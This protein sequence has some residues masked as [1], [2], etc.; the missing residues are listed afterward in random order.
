MLEDEGKL[1][2]LLCLTKIRN[3]RKEERKEEKLVLI[4]WF[5]TP[6]GNSS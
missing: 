4:W 6:S 3:Q 5:S 2:F 1:L